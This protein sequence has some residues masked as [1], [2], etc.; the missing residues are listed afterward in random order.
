MS[1]VRSIAV[2]DENGDQL[3]V[4]EFQDRRFMRKVR[5]MKLCTGELVQQVDESTFSIV[6]TGEMLSR[7]A[8]RD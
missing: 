7:I 5:R 2:S 4:Y 3:T 8:G 6:G 1:F